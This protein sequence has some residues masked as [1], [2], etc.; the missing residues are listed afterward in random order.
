VTDTSPDRLLSRTEASGAVEAIG[1]R[2]LLDTLCA[3]FPVTSLAGAADLAETAIRVAAGD[4]DNHLRVDLRPDCVQLGLQTRALGKITAKDV[5][6]ARRISAAVVTRDAPTP[7][8]ATGR[9]IRPVEQLELAIDAL[10]IPAI[11]PFWKAVLAYEDE[12]GRHGPTDAIVDPVGQLPTVWFQQM[13][14]P[15]PQ[16]NRI[17]L[18]VTVAHDEADARVAAA[19][20]AGGHMVSDSS[21]RMFWVL[22]DAEGNEC[23]VCTWSDRDEWCATHHDE[24]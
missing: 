21:A 24:P 15:R 6:L 12:P 20:A 8:P 4:A 7:A 19:L 2:Y 1:W 22:A 13:D 9:G 14:A 10:D 18:D 11:R 17:H 5:E 23:C 3:A 16:R